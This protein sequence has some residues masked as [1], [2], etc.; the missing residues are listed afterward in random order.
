[1]TSELGVDRV[2]RLAEDRADGMGDVADASP[3]PGSV[4]PCGQRAFGA[5]IIATLSGGFAS[6]TMK[7]MAA[8]AATPPL[9][10]ARSSVSRSPSASV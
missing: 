2:P 5:L 6:P 7:L 1:M 3:G 10:T 8:S 4:D 9:E